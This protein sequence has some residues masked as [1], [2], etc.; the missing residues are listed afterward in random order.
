MRLMLLV[1]HRGSD[2][3]K[4]MQASKQHVEVGKLE[5]PITCRATRAR[6]MKWL[7][8]I[9]IDGTVAAAV[10]AAAAPAPITAIEDSTRNR[11]RA[12]DMDPED[13]SEA[14]R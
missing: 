8:A 10:V 3:W 11:T 12:R 2:H 5:L 1:P 4:I 13:V 6:C 14:V 7:E 9:V